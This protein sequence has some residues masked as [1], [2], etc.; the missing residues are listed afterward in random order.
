MTDLIELVR[1][2]AKIFD[3]TKVGDV[4]N[5]AADELERLTPTEE[6]IASARQIVSVGR[7]MD[8]DC[9]SDAL[10]RKYVLREKT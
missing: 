9:K 10:L 2:E 1:K 8:P 7:L 6:D 5:K 3:N 4:L